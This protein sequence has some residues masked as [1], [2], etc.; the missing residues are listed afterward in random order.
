MRSN[1]AS[2]YKEMQAYY[3]SLRGMM[4]HQGGMRARADHATMQTVGNRLSILYR[5]AVDGA[6]FE[7][8][9]TVAAFRS[10]EKMFYKSVNYVLRKG[11]APHDIR[12]LVSGKQ[13]R[14]M[15]K[16]YVGHM[17]EIT[18][19][20]RGVRETFVARCDEIAYHY[21]HRKKG[22]DA[23]YGW[24]AMPVALFQYAA[25][26]LCP[27]V[28]REK[29]IKAELNNLQYRYERRHDLGVFKNIPRL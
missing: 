25:L 2:Q 4:L 20:P 28:M 3:K 11:I 22:H 10:S 12:L 16:E 21:V 17:R 9:S 8:R 5:Y 15:L 24:L 27:S 29:R 13:K 6:R 19:N 7:D 26:H 14:R 23:P 1:W 18:R